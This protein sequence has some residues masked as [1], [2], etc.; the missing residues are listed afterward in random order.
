VLFVLGYALYG[1]LL[2]GFFEANAGSAT[3][4]TREPF[5]FVSLVIAQ[6]A[7]GG[8]V[9]TLIDWKGATTPVD[10]AKIG[11]TAGALAFLGFDLTMYAT[12]NTSNLI[13]ALADVAVAT[14]LFAVTA[15]VISMVVGKRAAA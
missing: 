7:W 13:G 1:I 11:A 10:A 2:A 12:T 6:F 5:D 4:L 8:L 3:G 15:A 9:T 14:I